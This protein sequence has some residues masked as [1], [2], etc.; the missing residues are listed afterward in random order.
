MCV[1]HD[2]NNNNNLNRFLF[3]D[4]REKE[5]ERN[6]ASSRSH[7]LALSANHCFSDFKWHRHLFIAGVYAAFKSPTD[8]PNPNTEA[9]AITIFAGTS[10]KEQMNV[11]GRRTAVAVLESLFFFFCASFLD[12]FFDG[13]EEDEE[14]DAGGLFVSESFSRMRSF[15]VTKRGVK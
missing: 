3:R 6:N 9:D 1:S 11:H 4:E 13:D 7:L 14:D 12:A 10:V 2:N 8:V 15:S 5:K